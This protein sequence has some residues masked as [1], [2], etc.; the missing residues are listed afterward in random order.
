M[1][2]DDQTTTGTSSMDV[3]SGNPSSIPTLIGIENYALWSR[4]IKLTLLGRNKISLVDGSCKKED[5]R[6]DLRG[7]WE[8]VSAIVLSWLLSSISKSLFEGVDFASS[9]Q[10]GTKS[11]S[12]YFTKLKALW[13]EFEALVPSPGCKCDKSRDFVDHLNRQKMYQFLMELNESFRQARSQILLMSPM[14]S[15]NQP[16]AMVVNDECQKLTSSRTTGSISNYGVEALG[17]YSRIGGSSIAQGLNKFK[18]NY[19]VV[20]EF[21][22]CNGHTQDQCYKLIGYPSDFKSK[23]KLN[24]GAYMVCSD[25]VNTRK[26]GFEGV[27]RNLPFSYRN[28]T[29]VAVKS[30]TSGV[31]YKSTTTV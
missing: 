5:V 11:V 12:V 28:N 14:P 26:D 27:S 30:T 31:M 3:T 8:K 7:L 6:I 1:T 22:R 9:A 15:A 17:M 21:C 25:E 24:N 19:R 18:K 29:D 2:R 16:Y 23:R 13:D 10:S 4:S 20:C